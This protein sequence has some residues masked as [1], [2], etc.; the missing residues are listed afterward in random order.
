MYAYRLHHSVRKLWWNL[1][2]NRD[3]RKQYMSKSPLRLCLRISAAIKAVSWGLFTQLYLKYWHLFSR[4][5]LGPNSTQ[6]RDRRVPLLR[7]QTTWHIPEKWT[8][9][10]SNESPRELFRFRK[11]TQSFERLNV[12]SNTEKLLC[13][14]FCLWSER[15]VRNAVDEPEGRYELWCKRGRY[16]I[17]SRVE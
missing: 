16:T 14:T 8:K 15:V 13:R 7:S 5:V 17:L 12:F 9:R 1:S 2:G 4:L 11:H 6:S 10:Q 3:R